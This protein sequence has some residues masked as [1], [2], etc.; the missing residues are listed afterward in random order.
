MVCVVVSVAVVVDM[1]KDGVSM[2]MV[3]WDGMRRDIQVS[4]GRV[5]LDTESDV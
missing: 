4:E 3:F 2:C 1:M 5:Y